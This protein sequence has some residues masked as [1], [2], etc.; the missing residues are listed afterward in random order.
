MSGSPKA[1]ILEVLANR[2]GKISKFAG[3]QSL[4]VIGS[5]AARVYFRYS[6]IHVGGRAFFGLRK[7][8]LDQL[9]GRNSFI[10]FVVDDGSAP[11][12]VPYADFDE[13]FRQAEPAD[14]GQYK[15]QLFVQANARELYIARQGRFNVEGY[16]GY[17]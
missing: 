3:G 9:G 1:A 17:E 7:R 16:V 5:D 14:D 10:C 12:F 6:K 8:D 4:Y 15:A 2:F 13:L 11:L